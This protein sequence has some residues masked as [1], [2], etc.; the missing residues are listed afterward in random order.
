MAGLVDFF[1]TKVHAD[2]AIVAPLFKGEQHFATAAGEIKAAGASILR[3]PWVQPA[4]Q[5]SRGGLIM[6]ERMPVTAGC[7][8]RVVLACYFIVEAD[9]HWT[10]AGNAA[11]GAFGAW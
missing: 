7:S 4:Q 10:P 2:G 9:R 3:Q 6:R 1:P 8:R 5:T 11:P